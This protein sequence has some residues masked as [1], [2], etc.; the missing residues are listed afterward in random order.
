MTDRDTTATTTPS[1]STPSVSTPPAPTP[2]GRPRASALVAAVPEL[3]PVVGVHRQRLDPSAGGDVPAHV[4]VLW[5]FVAPD[6]LDEATVATL[7]GIVAGVPAFDCAFER[8]S[9]FDDGLLTLLPNPAEPFRVLT[10]AV[11]AAFPA[12]PPYGGQYDPVPHLTIGYA[13]TPLA[14]RETAAALIAPDLPVRC[15]IERL[16]LM[17]DDAVGRWSTVHVLELG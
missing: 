3:E 6:A 9:W 12:H 4:T 2:S 1:A 17:V 13:D 8:V 7:R 16:R 5:P 14:E 15:R 10:G 11:A